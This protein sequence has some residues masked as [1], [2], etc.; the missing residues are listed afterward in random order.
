MCSLV[1]SVSTQKAMSSSSTIQQILAI[2]QDY[3]ISTNVI[4]VII[5]FIGNLLNILV[6]TKLKLFRNNQCIFY[7]TVESI[8]DMGAVMFTFVL[9][10]FMFLYG[11]DLAQYSSVWCKLRTI[12]LQT[13][14]LL[15]FFAVCFAAIDQFL[16][17]SYSV[18]LRQIS[19]MNLARRLVIVSLCFSLGHSIGFG[20]FFNAIPSVDCVISYPI[21]LNYYSYFFYPILCGLLPILISGSISILSY[22]N[23]RRIIRRQLPIVRR[24]L[25]HQLTKLVL[26]R[27]IFLIIFVAPV[28]IYRIY[29][30]NTIIN[31]TD[32]L[33]IAI[34][35]L[36]LAFISTMFSLNYAVKFCFYIY[37]NVK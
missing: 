26:T 21:L 17:T 37:K 2:S 31:P 14:L 16:S 6:F 7:L 13:L 32:S 1:E 25:D 19:T 30:I 20:I 11:S 4:I 36:I 3:T 10:F 9:R 5:G 22:R 8:V 34:E 28:V 23:V 24:R 12:M 29:A 33:R 18:Y 35:R 15:S 27:V